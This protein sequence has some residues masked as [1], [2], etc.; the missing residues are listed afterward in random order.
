MSFV[1]HA[2][3]IGWPVGQSKSPVI[4]RFW[5]EKL[6]LDGDYGRFPVAPDGLD[7]AIRALP[8]LGLKGVNVTMPHK[9][10]VMPLLDRIDPLAERVGAVN[11]IVVDDGALVGYN[12]DVEGFLEP[13][14]PHL[15]AT[16]LFRLA[17]I[18]GS[19]GAARAVAHAL[20]GAGFTLVVIAR[21]RARAEAL[22]APF[23]P[24]NV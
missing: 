14:R 23:D 10:A 19:G 7:R 17:R 11:T 15:A 21:D 12:T 2:G 4:H 22:V 20:Y 6:G 1:G 8:A 13:L 9:Q 3:V 24:R 16:H 5:L 18:I